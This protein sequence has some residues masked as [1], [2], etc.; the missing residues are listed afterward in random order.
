MEKGEGQPQQALARNETPASRRGFRRH[1]LSFWG[2]PHGLNR[3]MGGRAAADNMSGAGRTASL[4][5]EEG[6]DCRRAGSV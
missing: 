3:D 1:G 6:W 2:L 5:C 4:G